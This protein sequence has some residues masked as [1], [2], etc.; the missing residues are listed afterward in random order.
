MSLTPVVSSR[1]VEA[2][3][4]RPVEAAIDQLMRERGLSREAAAARLFAQ[5][6]PDRPVPAAPETTIATLLE[7]Q[8]VPPAA[9]ADLAAGRLDA[10]RGTLKQAGVDAKRLPE[11][12]LVEREGGDGRVEANVLEPETREPSRVREVLKK[13]GLPLKDSAAER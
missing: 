10:L 12:K 5:R 13:L 2:L 6:F 3:R 1:D 9:I 11:M 7:A 8:T 4:R